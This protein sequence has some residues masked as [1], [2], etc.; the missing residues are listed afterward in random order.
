[1]KNDYLRIIWF[2]K[3]SKYSDNASLINNTFDELVKSYTSHKRSY[4]DLSHVIDLLNLHEQE[5]FRINDEEVVF[6]SI[7]F[8]DSIYEPLKNDNES[9]SAD[10]AIHFLQQINFPAGRIEKVKDYILATKTH[11]SNGENDLNLFLDFDLSILGSDEMIYDVYARQIRQEYHFYPNFLYNR[12]RKKV[13]QE[14]LA[15]DRIYITDDF[16]ERIEAQARINMQR[17]LDDL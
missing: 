4:H 8:H 1:M 9:K 11:E 14:L 12:G 10:W 3:A 13:L 5:A 15:K 7:W 16:F 2:K 6:F 17:E